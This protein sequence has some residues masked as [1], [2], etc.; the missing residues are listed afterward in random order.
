[1]PAIAAAVV[2]DPS[3][4]ALMRIAVQLRRG[5]IDPRAP[6]AAGSVLA[7]DEAAAAHARARHCCA[8]A[9]GK[10]RVR[11]STIVL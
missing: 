5:R 6:R 1:L 11:K 7:L 9:L 3:C 10:H 8:A 4:G 2:E